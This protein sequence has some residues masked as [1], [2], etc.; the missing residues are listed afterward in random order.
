MKAI[1]KAILP[2]FVLFF[3]A[4][5]V[6][7]Y[8][9]TAGVSLSLSEEY[10]DNIF[11]TRDRVGDFITFITPGIDLTARSVNSELRLGYS[12]S[13]SIYS[14]YPELNEPAHNFTASGSFTLSE[15]LSL[16]L[17]DTY[18]KSS[19]ISD[20]R[21][22]PDIGPIAGRTERRLHTIS[23]NV[24]YRLKENLSST[25][26]AS[27]FDTDYKEPGFFDT[28]SYSGNIGLTYRHSERTTLSATARYIKYDYK[29]GSD[30]TGQD[31][32]L[33]VTYILTPTLTAGL[34]GG[35]TITKIEDSGESDTGFFGG[36][37]LTKTFKR[38]RAT[39]SYSQSVI[40]GIQTIAPTRDQ[41]VILSLSR[42][43]TN[44]LAASMSTS[45]SKFESIETNVVD[46]DVTSFNTNLTYTLTPW[47]SLALSYSYVNQDDKIS[48]IGDYYNNIV[49]LN[50]SL[51]Y[52]RRL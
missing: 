14:S 44:K 45:Y 49:F 1:V 17:T 41:T 34:T 26:G 9:Y 27:Y 16:T 48:D 50:L 15:R 28:K 7:A 6:L 29:L 2:L 30:A 23:G 19:E 33:G 42:D 10:N 32:S 12:T 8:E 22:I 21:A 13:F 5:M 47:A 37:D 35:V 20:F 25:L 18:V 4:K 51:S 31:Y 3:S 43:I 24:S 11:V 36:V 39:L 40:S 46:T 38:G 52:S